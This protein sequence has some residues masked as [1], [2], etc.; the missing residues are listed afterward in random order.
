VGTVSEY[1]S[2]PPWLISYQGGYEVLFKNENFPIYLRIYF[3]AMAR[4]DPNRHT[5]LGTGELRKLMGKVNPINGSITPIDRRDI[6]SYLDKAIAEGLLDPSS[7]VH[8]LVLPSYLVDCRRPGSSKTCPVH[9]G[10]T[11]KPKKPV[12]IKI[13]TSVADSPI[14]D[15]SN[16]ASAQVNGSRVGITTR[17]CRDHNPT[18][19]SRDIFGITTNHGS[20]EKVSA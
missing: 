2:E 6:G 10:V 3:L 1:T 14:R 16:A 5:A 13:K 19:G 4:T 9:S 12:P 18:P 20:A 7:T 11:S 8:C 17:Q 15:K